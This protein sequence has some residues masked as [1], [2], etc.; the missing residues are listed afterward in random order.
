MHAQRLACMHG[1]PAESWTDTSSRPAPPFCHVTNVFPPA[2]PGLLKHDP[3]I[4]TPNAPGVVLAVFCTMTTYG[5][6]DERVRMSH[7][8]HPIGLLWW[9]SG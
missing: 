8:E 3:F 4:T 9:V 2:P 6:A 7:E 5:L 1:L